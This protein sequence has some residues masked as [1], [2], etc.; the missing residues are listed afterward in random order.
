MAILGL[1]EEEFFSYGH[2]ACAGCG[3]A[4]A[5]RL[6][7]KAAGKNSIIVEPTG[8]MEVTSTPYPETSWKVPWIHGA[9]ENSAAIASGISEALKYLGKAD[10]I[11]IVVIAGDG[12]SYDI[13]FGHLSGAFERGHN[14]T[15]ICY[16]NEA[17]MNTGIQRSGSTPYAASTTTSPAGKMSIGKA[18]W[19][20]DITH[21][22]AAH[23][24]RYVA[25]ASIA[26]P[27]DAFRKIKKAIETK[28]PTF[29]NLFATCPTG[30][31]VPSEKSIEVARLA[32]ETGVFPLYEI[33][34]GKHKLN[35][36]RDPDKLK[37]IEEYLK[38][39]GRFKH[40][41]KPKKRT[42]VIEEMQKRVKENIEMLLRYEKYGL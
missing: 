2:R 8:C 7:T 11:N 9:F 19:K 14:F 17:Y 41:F 10:K 31:R 29:V 20:K 33:E 1:P 35:R 22:L 16:D 39:Q 18:E 26:Y 38:I 3:A 42:D 30:W 6:I 27:N 15:Y 37:P 21:I 4:I 25:T 32:V 24:S 5:I 28:G 40:L 36:P 13:G 34:N 12:A 23:G